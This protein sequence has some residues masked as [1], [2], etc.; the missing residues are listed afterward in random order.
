[1]HSPSKFLHT[2]PGPQGAPAHTPVCPLSQ[3]GVEKLT[4]LAYINRFFS[5]RLA[6]NLTM[7]RKPEPRTRTSTRVKRNPNL[8]THLEMHLAY[9]LIL[10]LITALAL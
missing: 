4:T 6:E 7:T 3:R 10:F 2:A 9:V 1:M 8:E 5:R